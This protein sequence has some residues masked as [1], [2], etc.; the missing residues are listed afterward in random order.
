MSRIAY[1]DGHYVPHARACVHFED[2]GYQFADGVYEVIAVEA[3]R[4][5]DMMAHLNRLDRSLRAVSM[6]WPVAPRAL[7]VI[8]RE[9]LCRNRIAG[10]GL[11]YLQVTRGVAARAH[12]FPAAA[13]GV[14]VVSARAL[15]P[16]D[17]GA[18]RR[19]VRV[20]TVPDLRW[21]RV[22][23]KSISLLPN[24]LGK[25]QAVE[26]G[27]H[28]AWLVLD[29]DTVTEGTSSNAWIVS[30][31]G[32]V[33]TRHVDE[34]ILAGITRRVV[35]DIAA[36]LGLSFAERPFNVSE[37]RAARE[38]FLTSTSAYVTPVVRIDDA[39]VADGRIGPFTERLL[40]RYL[41]HL[42]AQAESTL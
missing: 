28:E 17:R 32:E 30:A 12:A 36:E 29:D 1:V 16:L 41:A 19:G 8:L 7:P 31:A 37:A 9:V 10:R 22:D 6:D 15:P 33:M 4:M 26:A 18:L 35:L 25:Q 34:A 3:G 38:A 42:Q 2:R 40:D 5:V 21:K 27:A 23:I 13:R 14:L 24:V 39:V 20:I 11:V